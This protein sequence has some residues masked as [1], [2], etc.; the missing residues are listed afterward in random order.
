MYKRIIA[1]IVL[2]IAMIGVAWSIEQTAR[3]VSDHAG[4][5]VGG[6]GGEDHEH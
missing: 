5:A 4:L 2:I 1:L 6:A 3:P